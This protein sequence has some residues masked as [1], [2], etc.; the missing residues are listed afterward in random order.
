MGNSGYIYI[1]T[2]Q[3]NTTLY[4]GVTSDLITRISQHKNKIHTKSFSY[5]YNLEKL[6]YY[7][8]FDEIEEAIFREKQLKAGSRKKKIDLIESINCDWDDLYDDIMK[9][10]WINE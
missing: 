4:V 6:V 2:N 1:I 10:L 8:I 7:E 9:D 5:K 3:N